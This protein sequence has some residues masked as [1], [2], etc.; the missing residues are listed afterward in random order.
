MKKIA[1]VTGGTRGIGLALS[2][3]LAARG[4]FIVTGARS[5]DQINTF[6]GKMQ[7]MGSDGVGF[8]GDVSDDAFLKTLTDYCLENGEL[9]V[10]I[11]NAGGG[12]R[13]TILEGP[14]ENWD[15]I[16]NVNLRAAMVLTHLALPQMIKADAEAI[17]NIVSMAGKVGIAG[18]SG[19]CASKFGLLGFTESL[20]EE[21]RNEGIKVSAICPGYVDTPLIPKRKALKREEMIQPSDVAKAL[22]FILD[23]SPS[24]CPVEIDLRPQRNPF[25]F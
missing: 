23:S 6:S 8:V 16:L 19:Y 14:V 18:S 10:L 11:N 5:E 22:G 9:K 12:A 21:V 15:H 25:K 4:Y 24:C 17:V 20:F 13:G 7:E 2:E 1:L 3:E